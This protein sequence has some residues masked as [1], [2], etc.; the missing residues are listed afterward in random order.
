M[1]TTTKKSAPKPDATGPGSDEDFTF[2]SSA[3]EITVRS[4]ATIPKPNQLKLVRLEKDD[5]THMASTFYLLQLALTPEG[6]ESLEELP[7]DELEKF[8]AEWQDHSGLT[9]GEFRAS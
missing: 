5:P 1:T 4:L 8:L 3:G 9:L 7:G 2:D 6:Y